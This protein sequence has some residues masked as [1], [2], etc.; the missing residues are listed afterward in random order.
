MPGAGSA[1]QSGLATR[2]FVELGNIE[3]VTKWCRGG[4][5]NKYKMRPH[6]SRGKKERAAAGW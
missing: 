6:Y 2:G 4:K 5:H 1:A 3:L